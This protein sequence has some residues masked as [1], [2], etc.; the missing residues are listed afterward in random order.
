[1][2]A[3]Q[4]IIYRP[5]T[6]VI[7][8]GYMHGY[9][10]TTGQYCGTKAPLV[11]ATLSDGKQSEI[12]ETKVSFTVYPNP[13]SGNFTLELRGDFQ[14]EK[15]QVDVYGILGEKVLTATINGERKHEFSLSARPSGVYF[16][17]VISG[18]KSETAKIIKQ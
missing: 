14:T 16:I 6:T 9:I 17:R 2:I 15:V 11:P 12:P 4:N 10:T 18:D 7:S 8:G 1:M 5:T 3:G 13:S